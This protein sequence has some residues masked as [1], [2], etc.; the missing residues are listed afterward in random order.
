[1]R[2]IPPKLLVAPIILPI[3]LSVGF[4]FAA[5]DSSQI[6]L[7]LTHVNY[8]KLTGTVVNAS[9]FFSVRDIKPRGNRRRGP[10][11]ELGTLGIESNMLGNC[12]LEFTTQNRFKLRHIISNKRLSRYRLKYKNKK[13]RKRKNKITLPCNA[14]NSSL[15][16]QTVGRFR[17]RVKA[18]VYRDIVTITVTTQ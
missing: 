13:I 18:G 5:T 3:L 6:N 8:V 10:W 9:R 15:S 14:A 1:M 11:V 17:N 12:D 7:S 16:F 2:R 4:A